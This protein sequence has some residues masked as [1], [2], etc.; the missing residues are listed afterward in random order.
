M[1]RRFAGFAAATL[2][3]VTV[4]RGCSSSESSTATAEAVEASPM[5]PPAPPGA[6]STEN[7]AWQS[8]PLPTK[9]DSPPVSTEV[10]P[11]FVE[12]VPESKAPVREEAFVPVEAPRKDIS[13][14]TPPPTTEVEPPR[15]EPKEEA[16]EEPAVPE[17]PA[18]A[19]TPAIALFM[20]ANE[21]TLAR[22]KELQATLA[23]V[24]DDKSAR[25]AAAKLPAITDAFIA[26]S[27][28]ATG[29]Y[30]ALSDDDRK[31]AIQVLQREMI[32][33]IQEEKMEKASDDD[34]IE[35]CEKIA[36]SP[37]R[38]IMH[39]SIV[40]MRDIMLDQHSIYVPVLVREKLAKRLGPKGS[41]LPR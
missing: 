7:V 22:M 27:K 18:D 25:E 4:G 20:K 6:S 11:G 26:Q 10:P 38:P 8:P 33:R 36:R 29:L 23:S 13:P 17:A 1:V 14:P 41:D 19:G 32:R 2:F 30:V 31:R 35:L 21:V 24:D 15:S 9:A 3:A 37:Q 16:A 28:V 39:D 12:V 5:V 40:R 34:L